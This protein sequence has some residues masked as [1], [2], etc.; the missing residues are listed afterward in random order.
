MHA[1]SVRSAYTSNPTRSSIETA[2]SASLAATLAYRP[3]RSRAPAR[4]RLPRPASITSRISRCC[5]SLYSRETSVPRRAVAFQSMRDSAS[6][7][8]VVAQL[9]QLDAGA[10]QPSRRFARG[11]AGDRP[12]A[13]RQAVRRH[14]EGRILLQ[15]RAPTTR[16]RTC[17]TTVP[18]RRRTGRRRGATAAV[19]PDRRSSPSGGSATRRTS[20]RLAHRRRQH[21]RVLQHDLAA[22]VVLE[23]EGARR[24]ACPA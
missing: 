8:H 21:A 17:L 18:A 15:R 14:G 3:S 16:A 9:Q 2:C 23:R 13:A 10:R 7:L 11:L 19:P 20:V 5:A 6:P 1:L 12:R 22:A 4:T 24:P